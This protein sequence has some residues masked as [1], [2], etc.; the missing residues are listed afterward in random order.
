MIEVA[1]PTTRE[2]FILITIDRYAEQ[3]TLWCMA[4][5]KT[6]YEVLK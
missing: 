1:E 3:I 6:V 5:G 2:L 4:V